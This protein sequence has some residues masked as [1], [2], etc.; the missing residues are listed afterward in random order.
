VA[1][2]QRLIYVGAV[3]RS[4]P[5]NRSATGSAWLHAVLRSVFAL[6]VVAAVQG[7]TFHHSKQ[8]LWTD[9]A[10]PPSENDSFVTEEDSGLAL[11]GVFVLSEP[12]HFAVLLDRARRHHRCTSLSHAQLDFYTDNWFIVAFPIARVTLICRRSEAPEP[13]RSDATSRDSS[14]ATASIAAP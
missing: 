10:E 3:S 2:G 6:A 14:S 8:A 4:R 12:D 1:F 9:P 5:L 11:L 13:P 7:C